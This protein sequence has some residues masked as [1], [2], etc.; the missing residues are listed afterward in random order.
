MNK[1]GAKIL[2]WDIETTHLKCDFGTLLC[3]GYR[4]YGEKKI[5]CP[6]ISDYPNFEK[7]PTDDSALV[8]DF[9]EIY[10]Q[11]DMTVGYYSSGFD[12]KFFQGKLMEHGF[13][14]PP[15]VPMVDLFYTVKSNLALSRKSLQNVGYFLNFSAEK[16]PVEGKI[17]KRAATGDRKSLKYIK[18]H[19]IADIELLEEAYDRLK[20]LVRTHPRVAAYSDCRYCGGP[21]QSRG[22]ALTATKGRRQKMQ[23]TKCGGWDTRPALT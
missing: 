6:A 15:K 19:C 17:W 16:T 3:V 13:E 8:K 20:P 1:Q 14:I 12:L 2:L 9:L 21:V 10:K 23:C 5:H 18:D 11:A 4:W 22:F 7:D